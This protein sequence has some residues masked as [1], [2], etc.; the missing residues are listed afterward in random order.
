[1]LRAL[2]LTASIVIAAA[3]TGCV[4]MGHGGLG[5]GLPCNCNDCGGCGD[6]DATL[7]P[8]HGGPLTSLRNWRRS[9]VCGGGCGEVYYGDWIN[10][11]PNCCDPCDNQV[12]VVGPHQRV[13][14]LRATAR[15]LS[16]LYGVRY[17]DQCNMAADECCCDSGCG[18][19]GCDGDCGGGCAGCGGMASSKMSSGNMII[20]SEVKAVPNTVKTAD[21]KYYD[22]KALKVR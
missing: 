3:S 2:L 13:R 21:K 14:P 5:G 22:P 10:H 8:G 12:A 7:G 20:A 15:L 19:S 9:L 18:V 1:M 11:P 16:G 17:C 4:G 6:C